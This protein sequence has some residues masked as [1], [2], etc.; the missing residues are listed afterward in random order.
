MTNEA[1]LIQALRDAYKAAAEAAAAHWHATFIAGV[2]RSDSDIAAHRYQRL[3][4]ETERSASL[5]HSLAAEL[6]RLGERV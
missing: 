1:L 3:L 6:E 5:A 2:I 4:V